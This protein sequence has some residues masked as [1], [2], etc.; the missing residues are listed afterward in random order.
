MGANVAKGEMAKDAQ[1]KTSGDREDM[2]SLLR[3]LETLTNVARDNEVTLGLTF[4]QASLAEMVKRQLAP[5]PPKPSVAPSAKKALAPRRT[6]RPR[7][8]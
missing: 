8:R 7:K 6:V 4:Q 3:V 5:K 2:A 1:K